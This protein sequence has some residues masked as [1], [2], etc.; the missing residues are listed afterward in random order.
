MGFKLEKEMGHGRSMA[1]SYHVPMLGA[2]VTHENYR[3]P[4]GQSKNLCGRMAW[5][6]WGR[7]GGHRV[8]ALWKA[9]W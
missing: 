1:T 2:S 4:G 5:G 8:L 9:L 7:H 3:R 6:V